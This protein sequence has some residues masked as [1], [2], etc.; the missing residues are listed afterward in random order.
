MSR[1]TLYIL[2]Y[3]S[4]LS[5]DAVHADSW[6]EKL[7]AIIDESA[8]RGL[9]LEPVAIFGDGDLSNGIEDDR[10]FS[11]EANATDPIGVVIC[12][13]KISGSAILLDVSAVAPNAQSPGI[14]ATAAHVFYEEKSGKPFRTCIF[15]FNS[16]ERRSA[17]IDLETRVTGDT[18]VQEKFE[19]SVGEDWAFARLKTRSQSIKGIAPII[20]SLGGESGESFF[21]SAYDRWT[22]NVLL[23]QNC[24]IFAPDSR[25]LAAGS[26]KELLHDCDAIGGASGGAI[27]TA[28]DGAQ[29]PRLAGIHLGH[30][31]SKEIYPPSKY[32]KGPRDWGGESDP[33]VHANYFRIFDQELMEVLVRFANS[34]SL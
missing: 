8:Y 24:R 28:M 18:E 9:S 11:K 12:D 16:G 25:N 4:A 10:Q 32:P 22:D 31:W 14:L 6:Q 21:L 27:L 20:S 3:L 30:I 34:Q 7:Q 5:A 33:M 1:I 29:G 26:P 2:I 23:S 17:L 13:G 15:R 19:N